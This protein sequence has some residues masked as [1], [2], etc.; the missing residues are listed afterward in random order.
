MEKSENLDL[1]I[2]IFDNALYKLYI[3]DYITMEE[4]LYNADSPN[5]LRLKINLSEQA[6]H[7][8]TEESPEKMLQ[9]KS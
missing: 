2:Q 6:S 1:G 4:S 9:I 7:T 5:N 8:L 3:A